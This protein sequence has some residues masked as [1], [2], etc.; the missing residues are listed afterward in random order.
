MPIA[1]F[2]VPPFRLW[3]SLSPRGRV[4]AITIGLAMVL[5]AGVACAQPVD[6]STAT[7][8]KSP[9]ELMIAFVLVPLI[10]IL[11]AL[12]AAV[13]TK[14][15]TFLHA[16]EGNSKIAGAFAIATD[17][18]STA[19]AHVRAGIESDLKLALADGTITDTERAALVA[20]L[21]ALVKLEL[22]AGMMAILSGALG[23]ALETWLSGKADQVV[24][25]AAEP[26]SP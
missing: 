19:F 13:L 4:V 1:R 5:L 11:G 21:V 16:K 10:P 6:S 3:H 9:L 7:A 18:V 24:R 15:V 8:P 25:A 20:K 23:P 26:P 2:E 12:I 17:F 22:P 14:L